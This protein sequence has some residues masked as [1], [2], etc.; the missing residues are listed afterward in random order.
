MPHKAQNRPLTDPPTESHQATHTPQA[1]VEESRAEAE[2]PRLCSEV[3]LANRPSLPIPVSLSRPLLYFPKMTVSVYSVAYLGPVS[4]TEGSGLGDWAPVG[5]VSSLESSTR[6][7][8]G[9]ST[10]T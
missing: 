5:L 9:C 7:P 10:K 8:V 2:R 3:L 1:E 4:C 6:L